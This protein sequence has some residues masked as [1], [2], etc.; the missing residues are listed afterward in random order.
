MFVFRINWHANFADHFYRCL[1]L[2]KNRSYLNI[3]LHCFLFSFFASLLS[4]C[5]QLRQH[6]T[7][8]TKSAL[9][10]GQFSFNHFPIRI[11]SLGKYMHANR[12]I[13][14]MVKLSS[15]LNVAP[16]LLKIKHKHNRLSPSNKEIENRIQ[17]LFLVCFTR[18]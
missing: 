11:H 6:K 10:I 8:H 9:H 15:Q 3:N 2:L 12:Q 7:K 5:F 13:D 17:I 18:C 16:N 14:I 1:L 4:F